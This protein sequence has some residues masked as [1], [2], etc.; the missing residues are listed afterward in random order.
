M[1]A[2]LAARLADYRVLRRDIESNILPLAGSVDGRRFTLRRRLDG[3][4]LRVG[5]Y[6]VLDSL[7][8][9]RLGQVLSLAITQADAGEIGWSGDT[10]LS[11]AACGSGSCRARASCSTARRSR[12]TTRR[13]SG[14]ARGGPGVAAGRDPGARG[15]ARPGD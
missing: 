2:T 11:H 8:G 15:P 3:L 1:E 5:G 6:V 13:A 4:R 10:T 7:G 14:R 9:P 12:S